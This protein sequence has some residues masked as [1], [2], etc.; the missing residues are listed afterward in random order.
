MISILFLQILLLNASILSKR[1]KCWYMGFI[2]LA[3]SDTRDKLNAPQF[4]RRSYLTPDHWE[5]RGHFHSAP[6]IKPN[7]T[8]RLTSV[9]EDTFPASE[10]DFFLGTWA[11][12]KSTESSEGEVYKTSERTNNLKKK[13]KFTF[14]FW[15]S[16][17]D[18]VTVLTAHSNWGLTLKRICFDLLDCCSDRIKSMKTLIVVFTVYCAGC[19]LQVPA[20]RRLK[21][22]HI[23]GFHTLKT[24]L[25]SYKQPWV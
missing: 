9:H 8:T 19:L 12:W 25:L 7:M 3:L 15:P 4:F 16:R 5:T 20:A 2:T 6:D 21:S 22:Q 18:S 13:K 24:F 17:A 14:F 10:D 11:A 23:T 1:L